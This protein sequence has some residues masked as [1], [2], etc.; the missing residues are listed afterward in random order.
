MRDKGYIIPPVIEPE[1]LMCLQVYIPND[2]LYLAAFAGFY[3]RLG[4]W[5]VWEKDGTNRAS[6]VAQVWKN[7][8]DYTRENGWIGACMNDECC[9]A[10]IDAI[11]NLELTVNVSVD[12]GGGGCCGV[13]NKWRMPEGWEDELGDEETPLSEDDT[14]LIDQDLCDQAHQT[15]S[16][17]RDFIEAFNDLSKER[18]PYA[19][20]LAFIVQLGLFIVPTATVM[21]DLLAIGAG[22]FYVSLERDT[23]NAWDDMKDDFVCGIVNHTNAASFYAWLVDYIKESGFGWPTKQWLLTLMQMPDWNLLYDGQFNIES[24]FIGS[25]C[26]HC[27][28]GI[29]LPEPPVGYVLEPYIADDIT[30]GSATAGVTTLFQTNPLEMEFEALG[31]EWHGQYMTANAGQI[32]S[33]A[34]GTNIMGVVCLIHFTDDTDISFPA[35]GGGFFAAGRV[36]EF[37]IIYNGSLYISDQDYADYADSFMFSESYGN[38]PLLTLAWQDSSHGA[39]GIKV[40]YSLW[41]L[42]EL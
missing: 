32:L 41:A 18:A 4:T 34:G 39:A 29:E 42:V 19:A 22:V 8:I 14:S 37:Q 27:I 28:Q 3:E 21:L 31:G 9:Q 33:R 30:I 26:T 17:I 6:Q 25:D 5:M 13:E 11:A 10:I 15:W 12:G 35:K 38:S 36:G 40:R 16:K 20:L 2:P 23:L 1:D 7:A 24:E